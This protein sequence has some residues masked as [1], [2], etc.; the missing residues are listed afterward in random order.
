VEE[1]VYSRQIY[2]QQQSNLAIEHASEN[3]YFTGVQGDKQ[4]QGELFGKLHPHRSLAV[5]RF[6][7]LFLTPEICGG[8]TH[9]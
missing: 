6:G 1:L 3:R 5:V 7:F 8:Q 4:R 2:K 9:P